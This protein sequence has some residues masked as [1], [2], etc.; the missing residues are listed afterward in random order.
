MTSYQVGVAAEAFASAL[1]TRCG[2]HVSVQYGANQP[3]YDL[4][5]EKE[6]KAFLVSVKGSQDG[7]WGLTQSHLKNANYY[8]AIDDWIEKHGEH[9]IFCFVQFK[10]IRI[11]DMPQV[12][13]AT[14]FEIAKHLKNSGGGLGDTILHMKK[15]WVSGKRAGITDKIP[16]EWRFSKERVDTVLRLANK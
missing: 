13:L 12:F 9:I 1:F 14:S 3:G 4:I 16:D 2:F 5:V 15:T 6:K 8:K 7:G 11:V 10:G